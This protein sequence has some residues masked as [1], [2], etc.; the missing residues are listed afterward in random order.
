MAA[1]LINENAIFASTGILANDPAPDDAPA[2]LLTAALGIEDNVFWCS[3][4]AVMLDEKV[5]YFLNTKITG[6][7]ILTCSQVS[8]ST[9]GVALTH[10]SMTISDNSFFIPGNGIRCEGDGIWIGDNKL[11]NT[12]NG[13]DPGNAIELTTRSSKIGTSQCQILANQI[14]GFGTAGIVVNTPVRDLIIKLNIIESCGNGI[15]WT[16]ANGDDEISIEN[17]HLRDIGSVIEGAKERVTGIFVERARSATIAGNTIHGLGVASVQAAL[18][19]GILAFSVARVRAFGN[20][21][22]ELGPAGDFIGQ[23]AGIMLRAPLTGFEVG[24][25]FVEATAELANARSNG[26]WAALVVVDV[27]LK[28]PLSRVEKLIAI[29][30]DAGSA[31]AL[32]AGR[33][34]L[35]AFPVGAASAAEEV[36]GA[37]GSILGNVFNARGDS[38]AVNVA[39]AECQFNDNRVDAALNRKVAVIL[40]VPIVIVNANRVIGGELAINIDKAGPKTAAVLGNITRGGIAISGSGLSPPWDA[41]NLHA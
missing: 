36:F 24:Q 32:G 35:V 17:N 31:L 20:R 18:R 37:K 4:Q 40:T 16:N 9:L 38:P 34:Q 25:N 6:N 30:L 12:G 10:S 7:D 1:A 41:L 26:D 29:R 3:R 2:F 28:N 14:S 39:V 23:T 27:D 8:V 15:I 19:A 22:V 13:R 33:P 5:M 11:V 21:I